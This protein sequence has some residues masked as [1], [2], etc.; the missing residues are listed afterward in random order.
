MGSMYNRICAIRQPYGPKCG[1]KER[2]R[3]LEAKPEVEIWR[4]PE[5]STQQPRLPI[6]PPIHR[7]VYLAP[8]PSFREL[9]P[10]VDQSTTTSGLTRTTFLSS[11]FSITVNL[12]TFRTVL[13]IFENT[14]GFWI[15]LPVH[16][17]RFVA[18]DLYIGSMYSRLCA[19]RRP[20]GPENGKK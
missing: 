11:T 1:K 12:T 5:F 16:R 4:R 3:A 14:S 15:L 9:S 17:F 2:H 18:P 7:S 10:T 8:L 19:I 6:W 13:G 20:N